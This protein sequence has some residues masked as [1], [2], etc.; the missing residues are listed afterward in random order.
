MT[1]IE[2][3]KFLAERQPMPPTSKISQKEIDLYDS[4]R[5]LF[6]E[7]P[8]ADCIPLFLNSFGAGDAY[9]AYQL[10][11][12]VIR[13]YAP[14]EVLSHLKNALKSTHGSVRYWCAQIAAHFPDYRIAEELIK[15]LADH[16]V[17]LRSA[18]AT[19]LSDI[20]GEDILLALQKACSREE[21]Q[22]LKEILED[23]IASRQ[24]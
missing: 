12:D 21:D 4:A 6:L 23:I 15:I 9:G 22:D 10:I 19:A 18:A 24:G 1:K 8:D 17:D 13:M 14:S 11:G 3:L 5:K 2:A 16:D 20:P 7:N